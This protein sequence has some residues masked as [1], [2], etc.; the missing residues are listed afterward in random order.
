MR[1]I[2]LF[3]F[4]IGLSAP[5]LYAQDAIPLLERRI[6]ISF[7]NEKTDEALKRIAAAGG[8]SFS[9]NPSLFDSETTFTGSFKN[10]PV[11]QILD[12][13]FESTIEYRER[14]RH[15][16]LVKAKPTLKKK[17][18][19]TVKGYVTDESTGKGLA[20]VTVYDPIKLTSS[21]TDEYG[22]FEITVDKSISTLKLANIQYQDTT[23]SL[24]RN[25]RLL[26][27]PLNF[28]KEKFKSR[29]DTVRQ[30][31]KRFWNTR[32]LY[33]KNPNLFN[34]D[35]T[36]LREFQISLVPFIGTNH[37]LSGNVINDFSFNLIG[38]YAL[39]VR[40]FELG[41]LFNIERG[42]ASN[43]QIAGAFNVVGGK[44]HGGQIAG[45]FNTNYDTIYGAQIAGV[46]NL[47]WQSASFTSIAGVVNLTRQKTEGVHVAGVSNITLGG[48]KGVQVSGVLNLTT[49]NAGPVQLAGVMNLTTG[50]SFGA[51]VSGV[52]NITVADHNGSQLAGILNVAGK[53]LTGSQIGLIN[54][55]K[56]VH[57]SQVGL[58]NI[59]DSIH[60]IPVGFL[61]IVARG[62]HK[63]EISADE[64][65]YTNL[66]FRTGVQKFYNILTVGA[67]PQTFKGDHTTWSFGYGIGTARKLSRNVFLNLD[68][69]ASQMMSD[70]NRTDLN[71]LN[72]LF[73]GVDI[74]A[75]KKFSIV[76]GAT[77]NGH[78]TEKPIADYQSIFEGYAPK[79]LTEKT[80][81]DLNLKTWIGGKIG[82]RFL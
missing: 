36:L 45:I 80:F 30:K 52:S 8:F 47:N 40:E 53:T 23:I 12:H 17:D 19:Q 49:G 16:I 25:G 51:Q 4:L 22:Y 48:A 68:L 76:V 78:L 11:R 24:P 67:K 41:G 20:N 65:F 70:P 14:S 72:K 54:L 43:V 75:T 82:L 55:S 44:F 62:Y 9:Y 38:G 29:A 39:G 34:I 57:G 37:K 18:E 61:S 6:T 71:M 26:H 66:S 56:N 15:I 58:I 13:I 46:A 31:I 81:D 28:D 60:G 7:S 1:R 64:V 74:Q 5:T 77:L 79:I 69:T 21:L 50:N 59:T 35:D 2:I 10:A 33:P 63:I 73:V 3:F 27:I 42:D 32:I